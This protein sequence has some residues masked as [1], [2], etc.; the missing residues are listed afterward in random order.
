MIPV[1]KVSENFDVFQLPGKVGWASPLLPCQLL[2][3]SFSARGSLESPGPGGD[4]VRIKMVK[5]M[6]NQDQE[7][8]TWI[9]DEVPDGVASPVSTRGV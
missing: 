2:S 8:L 3:S 5:V 1:E 6:L 7:T 4:R 9:E